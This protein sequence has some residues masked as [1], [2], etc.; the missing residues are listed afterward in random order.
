M[1]GSIGGAVLNILFRKEED[2][3]SPITDDEQSLLDRC[4]AT[5]RR[6]GELDFDASMALLLIL[7]CRLYRA[8]YKSLAEYA[9]EELKC[10]RAEAYRRMAYVSVILN[11]SPNLRHAEPL[12]NKSQAVELAR[13]PA[14]RQVQESRNLVDEATRTKK[15]I[16]A[17]LVRAAV[18]EIVGPPGN[19]S[20][21]PEDP[22]D[23]GVIAAEPSLADQTVKV[24]FSMRAD[25]CEYMLSICAACRIAPDNFL[26]MAVAHVLSPA[27]DG[28]AYPVHGLN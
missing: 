3:L 25:L 17:K 6:A 20:R 24:T 4:A 9:Q 5:F 11:L 1:L 2:S 21:S 12:P 19:K 15:R 14:A 28:Q 8:K 16:T 10:R 13:L 23:P 26:N 18:T 27:L 7:K 22:K